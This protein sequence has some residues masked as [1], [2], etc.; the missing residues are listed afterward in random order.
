MNRW[1]GHSLLGRFVPDGAMSPAKPTH[2]SSVVSRSEAAGFRFSAK[3]RQS[4]IGTSTCQTTNAWSQSIYARISG[5][6]G[7]GAL[8]ATG[9]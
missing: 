7:T 5:T 9:V 8:G 6:A 4:A 2:E 3:P 1:I